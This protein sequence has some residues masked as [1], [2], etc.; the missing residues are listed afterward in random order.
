MRD[1]GICSLL[2]ALV[3]CSDDPLSSIENGLVIYSSKPVAQP[4]DSVGIRLINWSGRNLQENLCPIAL[5]LK[6]GTA[7]TSVYSEPGA[8][9][10]CPAYL[11]G[12]PNGHAIARPVTLPSTLAPG[13]YRVTFQ[14][15]SVED[16]PEL[17]EES[18]ASQSFRVTP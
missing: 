16:G 12:F 17:P 18:R 8:G 7:W 15:L 6:Q 13:E 1:I 3:A 9:A 4:G 5:Q 14:W 11:R 10:A 2:V